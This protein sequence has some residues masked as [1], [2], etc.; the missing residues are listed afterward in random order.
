MEYPGSHFT[1]IYR[2]AFF[3]LFITFFLVLSPIIIMY[4]LGY[5]YDIKNGLLR[6][7]GAISID[8]KPKNI[9]TYLNKLKIISFI[10][11]LKKRKRNF[12]HHHKI[13]NY[14]FV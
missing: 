3:I 7:T 12:I 9:T 4:A 14:N 11:L 6:E 5:R 8:I 10:N 1:K 13:Q 2:R